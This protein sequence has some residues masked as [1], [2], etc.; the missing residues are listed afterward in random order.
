MPTLQFQVRKDQLDATRVAELADA[1]LAAGEVRVRIDRF[2]YTSNNITYA[3]FGEAMRYWQFF[4]VPPA[5]DG[6][7]WGCIPVWGFG[8]VVQSLHE[9]VAVGERLYGYWPMASHAVLQ[10][11]RVSTH[12]FADSVPHRAALHAV[13]NQ[14][15][16]CSADPYYSAD[17]EDVQ[18]L[19]R[20][21]FA[22]AWLIDDFVADNGFFGTVRA[23]APGTLLLSSASSKTAYATAAQL[24]RRA[25][26]QVVGLTSAANVPFCTSLGIYHR[27]LPYER[28][29]E[30]PA[31]APCVYVDFAGD[32]ALRQAVH[33]RFGALA[34]SC[35]IGGTH[36]DRLGDAKGLPGPKPVLFFAPAQ[37]K[38]RSADWGTAE[39]NRRLVDAWH[40]FR[41]RVADPAAPWLV[42]QH[43]AGPVAVQ[44]AH[45]LV[46][47]GRGDPRLGHVLTLAP[48][49]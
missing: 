3:A 49:R 43:H 9:G 25:E 42:V 5:A 18:A 27:V 13:Y 28:L 22:T 10:P 20:P 46:L 40:A 26:V 23:G 31:E 33:G 19:L 7:A 11:A 17:S 36:V 8:A 39:F 35:A 14:Y 4:P 21:L 38:K 48:G 15:Q 32:R 44:A 6:T 41:A 24:A 29:D 34:Y 12:G 30:L 47:A 1:A 2:A 16:R 37:I 45:A